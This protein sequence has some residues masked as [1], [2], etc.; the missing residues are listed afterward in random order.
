MKYTRTTSVGGLSIIEELIGTAA[1]ISEVTACWNNSAVL[2][3]LKKESTNGEL[4]NYFC[5][6]NKE[7]Q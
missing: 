3:R 2:E 7:N 5:S 4:R 6:N 1:E